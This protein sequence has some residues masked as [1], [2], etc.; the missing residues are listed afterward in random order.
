MRKGERDEEV[1]QCRGT[2]ALHASPGHV[3]AKEATPRWFLGHVG[4]NVTLPSWA[5]VGWAGASSAPC[6]CTNPSPPLFFFPNSSHKFLFTSRPGEKLQLLEMLGRVCSWGTGRQDGQ[7]GEIPSWQ[8]PQEGTRDERLQVPLALGSIRGERGLLH[9]SPPEIGEE[10]TAG[11]GLDPELSVPASLH[12]ADGVLQRAG[13][14][15]N[16]ARVITP[17][18]PPQTV[19][20][21]PCLPLAP[22]TPGHHLVLPC[23]VGWLS[24]PQ[25]LRHRIPTLKQPPRVGSFPP[26]LCTLHPAFPFLVVSVMAGL[27]PGC[28]LLPALCPCFNFMSFFLL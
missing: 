14:G 26:P 1:N 13:R 22:P 2:M 12:V 5:L 6:P 23:P 19:M 15:Q 16:F 21:L 4:A 9:V 7:D 27:R 20:S 10:P 3:P 24:T 25:P 28:S 17:K 11:L 8:P 18:A